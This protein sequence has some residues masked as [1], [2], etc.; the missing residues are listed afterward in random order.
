LRVTYEPH[1][2]EFC[3]CLEG[4]MRLT[5]AAGLSRHFR[6]GDAFAVPGWLEGEWCNLTPVRTHHAVMHFKETGS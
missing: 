2:E 6:A 5:D 4:E 1:E 3:V